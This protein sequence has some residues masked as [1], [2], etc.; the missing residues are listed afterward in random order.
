[1]GGSQGDVCVAPSVC[2]DEKWG[3]RG[4]ESKH[5]AFFGSETC[6]A[7]WVERESE[8]GPLLPLLLFYSIFH[9]PPDETTPSDGLLA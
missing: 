3:R 4:E 9:L 7:G 2:G 1:M 6:P 5:G 8:W